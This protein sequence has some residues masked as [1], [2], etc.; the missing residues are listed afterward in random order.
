MEIFD[1]LLLTS[2]CCFCSKL[3]MEKLSKTTM[4][5]FLDDG[6]MTE[7][8]A[9]FLLQL[10]GGLSQ[11]SSSAGTFIPKG[12]VLLTSNFDLPERWDFIVVSCLFF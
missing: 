7:N 9:E 4:V 12:S 6:K 5:A 11:G 2:I 3:V 10:Q 1:I 8:L